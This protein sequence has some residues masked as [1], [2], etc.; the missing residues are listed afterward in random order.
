VPTLRG[1]FDTSLAG[2][3]LLPGGGV[4]LGH[5]TFDDWLTDGPG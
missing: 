5:I 3:G 1:A 2:E 4:R